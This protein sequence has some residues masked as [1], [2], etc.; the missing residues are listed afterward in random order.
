MG[1]T[2]P[3]SFHGCGGGRNKYSNLDGDFPVCLHKGIL[4][5]MAQRDDGDIHVGAQQ[6]PRTARE[7]TQEPLIPRTARERTQEPLMLQET[8]REE[9]QELQ[10]TARE[11]SQELRQTAREESQEFRETAREISQEES[12]CEHAQVITPP[13]SLPSGTGLDSGETA[14]QAVLASQCC[15]PGSPHP[16]P[17]QDRKLRILSWN[18]AGMDADALD[19]LWN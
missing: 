16:E 13:A 3:I 11:E 12:H 17:G 4:W 6:K 15:V 19:D 7:R 2:G 8:A 18:A 1:R 14:S 9:T 10:E 5:Q